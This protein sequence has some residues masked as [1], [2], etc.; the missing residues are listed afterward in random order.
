MI[1]AEMLTKASIAV[2]LLSIE[3]EADLVKYLIARYPNT[4]TSTISY[5]ADLTFSKIGKMYW[6]TPYGRQ[7]LMSDN[8]IIKAD[9][10]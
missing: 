10:A 6:N 4:K 2:G 8:H 1:V 7:I 3:S 5:V 9:I